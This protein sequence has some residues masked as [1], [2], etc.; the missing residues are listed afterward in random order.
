[1][2]V[3]T[4]GL[5]NVSEIFNQFDF[6]GDIQ[7]ARPF[8]NGH[9]NDTYRLE[10]TDQTKPDYLLQRVNHQVFK[11]V[12]GMMDNIWKVTNH[13]SNSKQADFKQETLNIVKSHG[14]Q[15]FTK[16][17]DN[18]WRM[19]EFKKGTKSYDVVETPEQAFQ[20]ALAFGCFMRLLSD[21]PADT[22]VHT[23]PEFHN[24]ILRLQTFEAAVVADEKGRAGEVRSAIDFVRSMAEQMCEIEALRIKGK[25]PLRVTH[26]D[27]KF[28]NV[29]LDE[30]DKGVCVIDLDTVMPGVVHYDFGD[31][32]RTSTNTAEE[33]ETDLSL[34]HF[35]I[36]KFEGFTSGYL[37]ATRDIL[38]PV[39]IEYLGI[40]GALL[41]YI[42]GVRFLTDYLQGDVYYKIKHPQHNWDRSKVQLELVRQIME[43]QLDIKKII[44]KQ[45]SIIL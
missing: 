8:G 5:A 38:M 7:K 31:G 22:L 20:G 32:I 30:H 23:L 33:D 36:D 44:A 41:A 25:I 19:F 6:E 11:D 2:E 3:K 15:L 10:N 40:S 42:M 13:I 34:V 24:I 14:G 26:N 37:E 35:D 27:T 16:Q 45:A 4:D 39:E 1:M 12:P 21:F 28:N 18:Y 9:I 43:Q 29:L 17:E